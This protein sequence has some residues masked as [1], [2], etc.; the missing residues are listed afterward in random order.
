MLGALVLT[1]KGVPLK[2]SLRCL[3]SLH[4]KVLLFG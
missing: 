2:G 4:I 1:Q 3:L